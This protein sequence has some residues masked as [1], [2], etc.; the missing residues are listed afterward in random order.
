MY[1]NKTKRGSYKRVFG[2]QVI[3]ELMRGIHLK[4]IISADLLITP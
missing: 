2:S 3:S 1:V 4:S